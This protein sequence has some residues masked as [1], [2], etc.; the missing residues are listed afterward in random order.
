M[1]Q[2]FLFPGYASQST[3]NWRLKLKGWSC[4]YTNNSTRTRMIK[5]VYR[6]VL[7]PM[8]TDEETK[9]VFSDRLSG[10]TA[11]PLI[12]TIRIC[13]VE[14]VETKPFNLS[15]TIAFETYREL[16]QSTE[17]PS[18]QVQTDANGLFEEELEVSMDRFPCTLERPSFR[19]VAYLTD[20]DEI[21]DIQSFEL[22]SND[23]I[24]IISDV[25]D[26]IKHSDVY[27]GIY[28]TIKNA[29]FH[30]L[31]DVPGMADSYNLLFAKGTSFHYVSGGPF[32]F[33]PVVDTFIR[34]FNFPQGSLMLRNTKEDDTVKYKQ[35]VILDIVQD[36]PNRKFILIGDSG[37]KDV[38]IYSK[39][40]QKVQ[41]VVG[42]YIRQVGPPTQVERSIL[43][44]SLFDDPI[45]LVTDFQK[46]LFE[47]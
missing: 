30:D 3:P 13:V 16:I 40:K 31:K 20:D 44:Y 42:V 23:G 24:S 27:K 26:T 10:F 12:C 22:L 33:I 32:Q 7:S 2:L 5:S 43:D 17:F 18:V 25:D 1:K 19:L 11:N 15:E 41:N 36:F 45:E 39:V 47:K 34:K 46:G 6:R 35:K 9:K 29:L 37:E 4:E 14:C 28:S 8:G 21:F 38:E